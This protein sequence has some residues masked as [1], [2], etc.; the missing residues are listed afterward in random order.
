MTTR[1]LTRLPRR[2]LWTC[3]TAA[4]LAGLALALLRYGNPRWSRAIYVFRAYYSPG[5]VHDNEWCG[6]CAEASLAQC[7]LIPPSGYTGIW[8]TWYRNG[9]K[10]S[11]FTYTNGVQNGLSQSWHPNG[12]LASR[13]EYQDG[14]VSGPLVSYYP[15]GNRLYEFNYV[16]GVCDGAQIQYAEDGQKR[17]EDICS[18][19][20]ELVNR[21]WNK[22]GYEVLEG[23]CADG[24]KHHGAFLK[25][26]NRNGVITA[27]D[28]YKDGSLL[29]TEMRKPNQVQAEQRASRVAH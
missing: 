8:R 22:G 7:G 24:H 17:K 9:Q 12:V 20:V 19:G 4:L 15:N 5:A 25:E 23:Y 3:G 29:R 6:T 13:A 11:E 10:K 27:V 26:C 18:N 16:N 2:A 28:H 21:Y 1:V 14:R